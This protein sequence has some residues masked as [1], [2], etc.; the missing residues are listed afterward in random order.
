M[1]CLYRKYSPIHVHHVYMSFQYT[2]HALAQWQLSTLWCRHP[3]K[4]GVSKQ[5]K[6]ICLWFSADSYK[7]PFFWGQPISC[8]VYL[9]MWHVMQLLSPTRLAL[10]PLPRSTVL[11]TGNWLGCT[12]VILQGHR[13]GPAWHPGSED[14][15]AC[16]TELSHLQSGPS[17]IWDR[18]G[19]R[20]LL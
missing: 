20:P 6:R 13:S 15:I 3:Y 14:A 8:S 12:L 1:G 18:S 16:V 17:S 2:V 4:P 11:F 9:L 19:A 5:Q 7:Y 10:P